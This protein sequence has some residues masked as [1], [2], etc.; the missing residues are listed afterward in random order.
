MTYRFSL[1]TICDANALSKLTKRHFG[2]LEDLPPEVVFDF[3]PMSFVLPTGMV[4]LSNLTN[5]LRRR[6]G[7]THYIGMDISKA[8]IKFMD[9]AQFFNQHIGGPLDAVSR[10]RPT[11]Q[12]LIE[13]Q[14]SEA[15]PWV[16]MTLMPWL[17]DCAG[18]AIVDLAELAT[19][20]KELFNNI[21]DHTEEEVGS[22]FAQWFPNKKLLRVCI[23][24]FGVGIPNTIRRVD[25]TLQDNQAIARAFEDGFTSR[26]QPNNQGVGLYYLQ[27]NVVESLGGDLT[28]HSGSGV[29]KVKKA[30]NSVD[31]VPYNI[32]GYCP[33]TLFDIAFKTDLIEQSPAEPEDFQW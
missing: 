32:A 25:E 11:T 22:I 9:D 8:C 2:E 7:R 5:Y 21:G 23:A 30:G 3:S 24:D 15:L 4:F 29:L 12:P 27:Q 17:S 26:S 28:V 16:D 13:V 18:I 1:P 14:N 6:G 33:G 19:C 10:P 31:I 20:I